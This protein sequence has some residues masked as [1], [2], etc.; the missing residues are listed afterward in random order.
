MFEKHLKYDNQLENVEDLFQDLVVAAG[1]SENSAEFHN[2]SGVCFYEKGYFKQAAVLFERSVAMSPKNRQYLEHLAISYYRMQLYDMA[3][4]YFQR[5]YEIDPTD[6][7][8]TNNIALI[9]LESEQY[10]NAAYF[11]EETLLI[12]AVKNKDVWKTYLYVLHKLE[13]FQVIINI[14]NHFKLTKFEDDDILLTLFYAY[15]NC[16]LL[17]EALHYGQKVLSQNVDV[18]IEKEMRDLEKKN[19]AQDI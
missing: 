2:I 12:H 14:N 15:Y 1:Q 19:Y 6:C 5:I 13:L 11:L 16:S 8:I 7:D 17:Q 9:Y 3:I 4:G 10:H 18:D